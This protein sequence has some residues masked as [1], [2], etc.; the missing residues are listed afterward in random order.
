M[1][2]RTAFLAFKEPFPTSLAEDLA[3]VQTIVNRV[4]DHI[5]AAGQTGTLALI[6]ALYHPL[7]RDYPYLLA[8]AVVGW[9][10]DARAI[11]PLPHAGLAPA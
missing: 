10:F 6:E 2:T 1:A 3:Q 8:Q 7:R 11:G 4:L 9:A 5:E